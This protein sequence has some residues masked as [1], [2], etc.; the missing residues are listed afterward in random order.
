MFYNDYKMQFSSILTLSSN[1]QMD[2]IKTKNILLNINNILNK[3]NLE[4]LN[5]ILKR[6]NILRHS[7]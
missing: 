4:E 5:S 7:R 6:K 2:L 3:S 1:K